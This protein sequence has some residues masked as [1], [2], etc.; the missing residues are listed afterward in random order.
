MSP[1]IASCAR[2][3]AASASW[4]VSS[5]ARRWN[6]H[7]CAIGPSSHASEILCEALEK[8]RVKKPTLLVWS[9]LKGDFQHGS[10]RGSADLWLPPELPLVAPLVRA[11][12]GDA[13]LN[14]KLRF[15]GG[16]PVNHKRVY[17]IMKAHNLLLAQKYSER[18][19]HVHDGKVTVMRSNLRWCND[20]FEFTCWNGDIIPIGASALSHRS[21]MGL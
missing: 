12:T 13:I 17:R 20:G 7:G 11:T 9:P 3:K 19:E 21:G 14:R 2:W 6:E 15:D 1:A 10:G 8:S 4:K 18:P 5:G 16:V